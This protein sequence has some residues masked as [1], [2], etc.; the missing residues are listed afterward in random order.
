MDALSQAVFEYV[1]LFVE[2]KRI[3]SFYDIVKGLGKETEGLHF[4]DDDKRCNFFHKLFKF[5][6]PPQSPLFLRQQLEEIINSCEIN[7]K[8]NGYTKTLLKTNLKNIKKYFILYDKP[9]IWVYYPTDKN[10]E[11]YEFA[12]KKSNS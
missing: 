10:S 11:D 6:N 7:F 12:E 4:P 3:F 1:Y 8:Q 9:V 5:S 2:Q